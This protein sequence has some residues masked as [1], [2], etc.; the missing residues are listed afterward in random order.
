MQYPLCI[1]LV[2]SINS[3]SANL[4]SMISLSET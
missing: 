1:Y 3:F 2:S 4:V